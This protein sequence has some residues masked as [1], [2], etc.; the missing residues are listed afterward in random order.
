MSAPGEVRAAGATAVAPRTSLPSNEPAGA[1]PG[2]HTSGV[3]ALPGAS[4]ETG[5]AVLPDEKSQSRG[6]P[7]PAQGQADEPDIASS[8]SLQ[9]QAP[10]PGEVAVAPRVSLPSEEPAGA[11]PGEHTTGVGALPGAANETGVAVLPEERGE[12]LPHCRYWNELILQPT[13]TLLPSPLRA[14]RAP[15][16]ALTL[17]LLP[18]RLASTLASALQPLCLPLLLAMAPPV[19]PPTWKLRL[20]S[21]LPASCRRPSP[22]AARLLRL[23]D[24]VALQS[25]R[26]GT[27]TTGRPAWRA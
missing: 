12:S 4:T 10:R 16:E 14:Q 1:L 13:L 20:V 8:S 19:A 9:N 2:E 15:L 7:V 21:P 22:R 23:T 6:V 24:M 26:R 18:Q 17:P 5:V 27:P 25:P 11:L 3:G